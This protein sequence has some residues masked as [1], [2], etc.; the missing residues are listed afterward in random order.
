MSDSD[1]SRDII[2]VVSS[3]SKSKSNSNSK[4]TLK[5]KDKSN[6]KSKDKLK[7]KDEDRLKDESKDEEPTKRSEAWELSHTLYLI[8]EIKH[9][10]DLGKGN[11]GG[12]KSDGWKI[13]L[14]NY[15]A[16][17]KVHAILT[18]LK[19]H[20]QKLKT[21]YKAF[22]KIMDSSGAPGTNTITG[23]VEADKEWWD[24][25][26]AAGN[27]DAKPIRHGGFPAYQ[28]VSMVMPEKRL[29]ANGNKGFGTQT[30]KKKQPSS[31]GSDKHI[32]DDVASRHKSCESGS[33]KSTSNGSHI[34]NSE[35]DI[36]EIKIRKGSAKRTAIEQLLDT[37]SDDDETPARRFICS[38]RSPVPS[39]STS[40]S[41]QSR[42]TGPKL[43]AESIN[44][45]VDRVAGIEEQHDSD[46]VA[47]AKIKLEQHPMRKEAMSIFNKECGK[48]LKPQ[49][50]IKIANELKKDDTASFFYHM[51]KR[52]RWDWLKSEAGIL[53][54]YQEVND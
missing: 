9:Q 2:K 12:L 53:Q 17:F 30:K 40:T 27:P 18:R 24:R 54:E 52:Y 1:D 31:S 23:E 48:E 13:V 43:V 20:F 36:E 46:K 34:S 37:D 4:S 11:D 5:S 45:A 15:N 10:M 14:E 35:K 22:D 47:I 16:K 41:K 26:I 39:G 3:K 51:D 21:T 44:S 7:S 8:D 29:R 38:Q 32:E 28:A 49:H 6:S 19:N 25:W 50:I 42:V 33:H